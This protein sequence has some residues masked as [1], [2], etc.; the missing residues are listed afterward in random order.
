MTMNDEKV[1]FGRGER[2]LFGVTTM[3]FAWRGWRI[4][5][6]PLV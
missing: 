4:P 5:R 6:K 3:Q 1:R 2:G